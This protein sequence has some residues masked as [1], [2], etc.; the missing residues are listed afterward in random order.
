MILLIFT[1]DDAGSE[2][3]WINQKYNHED[4]KFKI[5]LMF[6]MVIMIIIIPITWDTG[7]RCLQRN[8]LIPQAEGACQQILWRPWFDDGGDGDDDGGGGD[9]QQHQ[10]EHRPDL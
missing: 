1:L 4:H 3:A 5:V 8:S 2:V 10:S 6:I 9:Q 7:G